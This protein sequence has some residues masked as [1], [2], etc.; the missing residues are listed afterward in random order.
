MDEIQRMIDEGLANGLSP[1]E[2]NQM[3][4]EYLASN[5]MEGITAETVQQ[6]IA[7][8]I[9]AAGGGE[10]GEGGMS[11][12]DIQ[13]LLDSGYMTADQINALM[14]DAGYLGQEGVDSSVQAALD[15]ALGEGGAINSA[16][17]AAM[18]SQG[19]G[20][21]P[22]T[23][24][25][26]NFTQPYTPGSFPTNPY[27]EVNPYALMQ[28]QFAG[29][30]PF[31]GGTT[32]GAEMPTGLGTLNFGD[33]SQYNFDIPTTPGADLYP[34]G[35]SSVYSQ[36]PNKNFNDDRFGDPLTDPNHPLYGTIDPA[37]NFER[38]P[39]FFNTYGG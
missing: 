9:A 36:P 26:M 31:S 24:T 33:P 32:T 22:P 35:I 11:M 25:D 27:G 5:P 20:Q 23:D 1:E 38:P 4:S 18:Q 17:A 37:P 3:I 14:S 30:T 12:E 39:D 21:T 15:A 19:G 10:S 8:A 16:I 34:S 2:I 13:A 29:T 6:M 7:D 28:G